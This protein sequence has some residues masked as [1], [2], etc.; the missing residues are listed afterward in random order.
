MVS[1]ASTVDC[2]DILS[3]TAPSD[4]E[5]SGEVMVQRRHPDTRVTAVAPVRTLP[6]GYLDPSATPVS[7][8]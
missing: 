7:Q 4:T 5:R 2:A 8:A 3:V 6:V 1:L